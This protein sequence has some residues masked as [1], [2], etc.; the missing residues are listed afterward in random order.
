M[1]SFNSSDP[2]VWRDVDEKWRWSSKDDSLGIPAR[3]F[4]RSFR[5]EK[6]KIFLGKNLFAA[7]SLLA[8]RDSKDCLRSS[9]FLAIVPSPGTSSF[10]Q[11]RRGCRGEGTMRQAQLIQWPKP[12]QM[13][14]NLTDVGRTGLFQIFNWM[15]ILQKWLR[16]IE[17]KKEMIIHFYLTNFVIFRFIWIHLFDVLIFESERSIIIAPFVRKLSCLIGI[18]LFLRYFWDLEKYWRWMCSSFGSSV[19]FCSIN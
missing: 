13:F 10:L 17:Q 14:L 18:N 19:N 11:Y 3:K 16:Y 9:K 4:W 15:H 7:I 2:F 8:W 5:K 6:R 1:H 12:V